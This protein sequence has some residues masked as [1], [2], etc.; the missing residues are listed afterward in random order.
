[1]KKIGLFL[2]LILTVSSVFAAWDSS[3]KKESGRLIENSKV[4][5]TT[6][7]ATLLFTAGNWNVRTDIFNNTDFY[8]WIGSNTANL[9]ADTGA[10]Y[11]VPSSSTYSID[12]MFTGSIYGQL[13]DDAGGDKDVRILQF[14]L[15]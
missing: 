3:N 13:D 7:T 6:D 4:T 1:M 5:V 11:P 12:G 14:R 15:K 2:I 8:L 10:G 9:A